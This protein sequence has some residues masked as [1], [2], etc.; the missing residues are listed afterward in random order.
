MKQLHENL[1]FANRYS[2]IKLLGRGGFSEVWLAEDTYTQ[3]KIAIKIYA[4]GTGMDENGLLTFSKELAIVYDLNHPNLLRPQ[5]V[6]SW[7]GMP[8]L[9]MPYCSKGSMVKHIEKLTENDIWKLISD[10]SNGMQYLH[11]RDII[12]QDIKP[13]NILLDES[14][15]YVITD[16]GISTRLRSTLRKSVATSSQ[17]SGGTLAYMGA[18]RFGKDP[19]PIK[20]SDIWS[21]GAMLFELITG[22]TPFGEHGG[23]I[24]KSGAEIP[25]IE[26]VYSDKLKQLIEQMLSVN[27]WDRPTFSSLVQNKL[28]NT[29]SE[30]NKTEQTTI[31]NV[32]KGGKG[33]LN[34]ILISILGLFV[35]AGTMTFWDYSRVKVSY[36]K[37]YVEQWGI[38]Q[39]IGKL[40]SDEAVHIARKYKFT[41]QH[42]KLQ[43][44]SHVNAKD[45]IISDNETERKDR[46]MHAEYIYDEQDRLKKVKI[47]D[48]NNK[49]LYVKSYNETLQTIIFQYDDGFGTE[50]SLASQTIGS[51]SSIESESSN[52]GNISRYLLEYDAN[53]YVSKVEYAGFQNIRVGDINNIYGILYT[54]DDKGRIVKEQYLAKDGSY[55]STKWGL[56][57][58]I[59]YYDINDN[60]VRVEYQTSDGKPALDDHDGTYV[61]ELEY[62][63]IGNVVY[64]YYLDANN[65]LITP[66]K[67]GYAGIHHTYDMGSVVLQEYLGVDRAI[68]YNPENNVAKIAFK[69]DANGFYNII[70][71]L[72]KEGELTTC[73]DGYATMKITYD[74]VGNAKEYWFYDVNDNL[75]LTKDGYAGYKMEHDTLGNIIEYQMFG[76]TGSQILNK[77]GYSGYTNEY[78]KLNLV[79][80][81]TYLGINRSPVITN[82]SVMT[83]L[84]DYDS[85]G[86]IIKISFTKSD[87]KTYLKNKQGVAIIKIKHDEAGNEIERAFYN[88][89]ENLTKYGSETFAYWTA[90]YDA[91]NNMISFRYYDTNGKKVLNTD[92]LAGYNYKY[93]ERGNIIESTPVDVNDKVSNNLYQYKYKYDNNDNQIEMTIFK[94]GKPVKGAYDYHKVKASYNSRNQ[95]VENRY[96]DVSG[97]L[98]NYNSDK[99]AIIRYEYDEKGYCTITKYYDKNEVPVNCESGYSIIKRDYDVLGN[100]SHQL[101][102]TAAGNP[103]DINVAIPEVKYEYDLQ[104]NTT[105]IEILN[106]N[107]KLIVNP[108]TGWAVAYYKYDERDNCIE[109]AYYDAYNNPTL[110]K[111]EKIHIQRNE[112]DKRGNIIS[113]SFFGKNEEAILVN[114][115]HEE[116]SEFDNEN[117]LKTQTCYGTNGLAKNDEYGTHKYEYLYKGSEQEAYQLKLYDVSGKKIGTYKWTKSGW[118]RI[119]DWREEIRSFNS[120]CPVDFGEDYYNLTCTKVSVINSKRCEFTFKIPYNQKD[121][122]KEAITWLKSV[123]EEYTEWIRTEIKMPNSVDIYYYFYDYQNNYIY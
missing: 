116:R 21:F 90:I 54:H 66:K 119:I 36:Y 77:D 112:F 72:D 22:N 67:N 48:C 2:L 63:N 99:Y 74:S 105:K 50:K 86:N 53:G 108:N 93:D 65:N 8:Y 85:K 113:K 79:S 40:T 115:V 35:I 80:K 111:E 15:N 82:D 97:N 117:R 89:Y 20:A 4:P 43:S 70:T 12:H 60:L 92:G 42:W 46:P 78:N 71:C 109:Y 16:F 30:K 98:T 81:R 32:K 41:Y 91:N 59:F 101:Y 121:F 83:I 26:G 96:Y 75:T 17:A 120:Y 7:E 64:E 28:S 52:K 45:F 107:G 103:T 68:C 5:H 44:I 61:Y 3:L 100:I 23:L 14:G 29:A 24:Q 13:D 62:D 27:P 34:I 37:D 102:F 123:I 73:L 31:T 51:E 10:V 106:G 118:E 94:A 104:G 122:S 55:K 6:D 11:E 88:E 114:G 47:K 9:I 18:E 25:T 38:P 87:G 56:G 39:G 19:Q 110:T 49:V 57:Q 33:K 58:K 84:Y 95:E 69:V 1:M 76:K